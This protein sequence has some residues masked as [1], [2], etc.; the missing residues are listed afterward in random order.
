[1][2]VGLPLRRTRQAMAYR[3]VLTLIVLMLPWP[4][5]AELPP[6]VYQK[7]QREAPEHVTIRVLEVR[8]TRRREGQDATHIAVQVTGRVQAVVRSAS[9]LKPGQTIRIAYTHHQIPPP[10][11]S[12]TPILR[13]G[14]TYPAFLERKAGQTS[15]NPAAGGYSFEVLEQPAEEKQTRLEIPEPLG[16]R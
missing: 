13:A 8:T 6:E 14:K 4:A 9:G 12:Q 10:G 15:Y 1:M 3:V 11:P 5:R 16:V 2:M 7:W